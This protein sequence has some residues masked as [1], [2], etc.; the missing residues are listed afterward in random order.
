M[1]PAA[2]PSG[3]RAL[4]CAL[5]LA[6]V[7]CSSPA[8]QR[9]FG[10]LGDFETGS[11]PSRAE[12]GQAPRFV[13]PPGLSWSAALAA[14]A[15]GPLD[16]LPARRYELGL[17]VVDRTA[18]PGR[19][20]FALVPDLAVLVDDEGGRFPAVRVRV[21][22]P[23]AAPA[24]RER[25]GPETGSYTL[26]FDLPGD[27]RLRTIGRVAVHWAF[28]LDGALYRVTTLFR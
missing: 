25:D 3:I 2:A 13:A 24:R 1:P 23:A 7:A 18:E 21:P 6:A 17:T 11:S 22:D 14:L 15:E 12:G 20:R 19:W 8:P 5:L 16:D 4:A 10:S 27:Y 9:R 26:V 28:E